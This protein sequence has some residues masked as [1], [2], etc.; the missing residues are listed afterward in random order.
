MKSRASPD[1]RRER[2]QGVLP[3]LTQRDCFQGVT[4]S[5]RVNHWF[6]RFFLPSKF[7]SPA[8]FPTFFFIPIS[9]SFLHFSLLS[10]VFFFYSFLFSNPVH[11]SLLPP[12]TSPPPNPFADGKKKRFRFQTRFSWRHAFRRSRLKFNSSFVTILVYL[13]LIADL[14]SADALQRR[15]FLG[16]SAA[17]IALGGFRWLTSE[18]TWDPPSLPLS[19]SNPVVTAGARNPPR[20][21]CQAC[22]T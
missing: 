1:C 8:L 4:I 19:S 7:S 11:Q 6:I 9:P 5:W 20:H 18:G 15:L 3:V 21:S 10:L 22:A 13:K 12:P 14:A 2:K 17:G 16:A